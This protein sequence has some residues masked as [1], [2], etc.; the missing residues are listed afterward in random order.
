MKDGENYIQFVTQRSAFSSVEGQYTFRTSDDKYHSITYEIPIDEVDSNTIIIREYEISTPENFYKTGTLRLGLNDTSM[1]VKY[2]VNRNGFHVT[3]LKSLDTVDSA[4]PLG[5]PAGRIIRQQANSALP[6]GSPAGR[7][8]RNNRPVPNRQP[9]ATQRPRAPS[10]GA[11][12][13]ST[14]LSGLRTLTGLR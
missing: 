1:D 6:L 4:L 11:T 9:R 13:G 12:L 2:Y 10:A 14:L 3:D 7:P 5:T 8:V